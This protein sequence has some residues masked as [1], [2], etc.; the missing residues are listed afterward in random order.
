M[1][2]QWLVLATGIALASSAQAFDWGGLFKCTLDKPA[3]QEQSAAGVDSLS[4]TEINSGL[5]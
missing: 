5:K 1:Q 4:S 2:K 3:A